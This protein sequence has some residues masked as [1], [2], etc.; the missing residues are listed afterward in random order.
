MSSTG[1]GTRVLRM[2]IGGLITG[3]LLAVPLVLIAERRYASAGLV[4]LAVGTSILFWLEVPRRMRKAM[5]RSRPAAVRTVAATRPLSALA[6]PAGVPVIALMPKARR[7]KPS[8]R[9][10]QVNAITSLAARGRDAHSI[11][12][13]LRVPYDVVQFALT[14]RVAA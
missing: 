6:P 4:T 13:E 3:G 1:L 12:R 7:Y 11:A 8:T 2:A 10:R 9:G 14:R 5:R